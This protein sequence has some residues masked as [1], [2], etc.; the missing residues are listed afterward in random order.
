MKMKYNLVRTK[1]YFFVSLQSKKSS[2]K[3]TFLFSVL[4]FASISLFAKI[5]IREVQPAFWWAGMQ[6]AELQILLYGDKIADAKV[7]IT[8]KSCTLRDI[9]KVENSNYLILYLNT[10]NAVP[11]TFNIVLERGKEKLSIPYQMKQRKPN[12]RAINGFDAS[13]VMYLIMPDRFA[14]GDKKNDE[15]FG[16]PIDRKRVNAR[17]GGDFKG[18]EQRIDYLHDLGVTAI[19]LNPVL[20]NNMNENFYPA[21]HGYATTN[22]YKVDARFGTN[23][24]YK[25]LAEKLHQKGMKLVM[26]MIFNHCGSEN[27]LFKDMISTDWFNYGKNFVASSHKLSTQFDLYAAKSDFDAAINGWFVESMPDFNQRNPHVAK[28]LIQNS[29]WWIEYV[30]LNGIRQDTHPYADYDMMS[31]WC[32]AVSDEYPDFNIV[33]ETWYYN[34]VAVAWWQK[35]SKLAAPRNSHLKSVMDFPLFMIMAKCFDEETE[36]W[37]GGLHAVYDYLTQDIVYE[38]PMNLLV[39]FDNHDTDRFNKTE[40]DT[41][42][43]SRTKQALAFILTTRGI[44]QIYYGTEI[45]MTG[46]KSDGDGYLRKDFPGGWAEDAVNKFE[47]SGRTAKENEVFEFTKHLLNWRKGNEILAKGNLKHFAPRN[48]IYAYARSYNGKSVVVFLNG[49][50]SEKEIDLKNYSEILP[51]NTA[52]EV[53][54]GKNIN[55]SEKLK[56]E[57]RGVIILEF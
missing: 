11:E 46:L 17:H 14:N 50:N 37:R 27:F 36:E 53:I 49:S 48:S 33:G 12:A 6:N 10:Q 29:I 54:T 1:L 34:N 31:R 8:S 47:K 9:T 25:N 28:Y 52:K 35:D 41:A 3:K 26:D 51:K 21:Y 13:D 56:I 23:E 20:E 4:F 42:N 22:F 19:W 43:I 7:F 16:Y 44:P 45:L 40:A 24:D 32:K 30:G 39:F 15:I 38:D 57:K 2:M 18:I 5:E 55:L